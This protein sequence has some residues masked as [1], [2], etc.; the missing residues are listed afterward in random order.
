MPN[1]PWKQ[2]GT[3]AYA[4]REAILSA[5]EV[6]NYRFKAAADRLGIGRSTLYRLLKAFKIEI[7]LAALNGCEDKFT[8]FPHTTDPYQDGSTHLY[9]KRTFLELRE[10]QLVLV[11]IDEPSADGD[12]GVAN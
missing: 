7:E 2:P 1:D 9:G 4:K 3:M 5:L 10:D 6:T 8:T 11:C 12:T